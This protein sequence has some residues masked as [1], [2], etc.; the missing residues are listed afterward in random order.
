MDFVFTVCDNAAGEDL[1]GLAGPADDGA[2]GRPRPG[3]G[4][5]QRGARVALAFPDAYR[6]LSDRIAIFVSLPFASLDRMALQQRLDGDRQDRCRRRSR[7]GMTAL[8]HVPRRLAAEAL[9]TALLVATVVGSGIMAERLAG[10]NAALAL[11]GN[12]IATGASWSC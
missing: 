11:L 5:G 3:G 7:T 9:G 12:T 8:T 4:D 10:G 1:P 2:L 6:R